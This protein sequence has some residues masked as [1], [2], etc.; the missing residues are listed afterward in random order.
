MLLNPLQARR[1]LVHALDGGYAILAVNADSPAAITDCLEA[2]LQC[3][4]PIII[5]ASLWQ[6]EGWSFGAGDA[7]LGAGRYLA[8]LAVLAESERYKRIPVLF[9]TDHIKG[10]KTLQILKTA[11]RGLPLEVNGGRLLLA[12]STISLDSSD[13]SEEEN[14][15]LIAE[16]AGEAAQAGVPATLEMEAGIDAGLTDDETTRRVLGELEERQPGAVWLWAPGLGTK[17]GFTEDGYPAFSAENTVRQKELAAEI[18]GR[19]VGLALHG[20]SGLSQQGLL[21]A[22]A[23]GVVKVNWSSESLL[24]RSGAAADYFRESAEKLQKSHTEF[25]TTAMDNGVQRYISGRYIPRVVERIR[26]LGGQGMAREV[27]ARTGI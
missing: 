25:K 22:V 11:L 13:L 20:S 26:V 24:I 4:A 23:S 12:P 9:H 1:L 27:A 6:L 5:E 19:P 16:L 21:D 17:H 10:P 18:T 14:I 2:A 7:I 8:Q 3:E 15:A